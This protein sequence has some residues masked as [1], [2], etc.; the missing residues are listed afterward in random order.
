MT[1]FFPNSNALH[2]PLPEAAK[3][4]I[5]LPQTRLAASAPEEAIALP[6]TLPA[7]IAPE[8]D[9][10]KNGTA[11]T[12]RMSTHLFHLFIWESNEVNSFP[13]VRSGCC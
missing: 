8:G 12:G 4:A 10:P 7:A 9:I 5:A 2:E 3:E 1:S 11:S 6:Q 13:I